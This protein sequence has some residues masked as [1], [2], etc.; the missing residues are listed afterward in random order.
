MASLQP[1][2]LPIAAAAS[3]VLTYLSVH[4]SKVLPHWL[5]SKLQSHFLNR[6][7]KKKV[8]KKNKSR[9][10]RGD[11]GFLG[12]QYQHSGHFRYDQVSNI[13]LCT[14]QHV[15]GLARQWHH[16][17]NKVQQ[18]LIFQNSIKAKYHK[19]TA[20]DT[21]ELLIYKIIIFFN[22]YELENCLCR[23]SYHFPWVNTFRFGMLLGGKYLCK[24]F[25]DHNK[26]N[27]SSSAELTVL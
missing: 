11:M 13:S 21:E 26:L 24:I 25:I 17:C 18:K 12:P 20:I 22:L 3:L 19:L 15:P 16:F 7:P 9:K 5:S 4:I 8:Q 10:E 1:W 2:A 23:C 27:G 14:C 6:P